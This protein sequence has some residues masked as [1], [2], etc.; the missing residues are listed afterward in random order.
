[1][2]FCGWCGIVL[3]SITE[4]PETLEIFL[5]RVGLAEVLQSL[6]SNNIES[7]KE[8]RELSVD[9]LEDLEI[10]FGDRL[11][12]K[13]VLGME[14]KL[15]AHHACKIDKLNLD[16]L[17][18]LANQNN[19]D[20]MVLLGKAF[21][22]GRGIPTDKK[23]A[24]KWFKRASRMEHPEG[25]FLYSEHCLQDANELEDMIEHAR[26]IS[27]SGE[28]GWNEARW[29][30]EE[31][32]EDKNEKYIMHGLIS[33][34][35]KALEL[36][37]Q[38]FINFYDASSNDSKYGNLE[39]L[40]FHKEIPL[41]EDVRLS[42]R[43][44]ADIKEFTRPNQIKLK[45]GALNHLIEAAEAG[46]TDAISFLKKCGIIENDKFVIPEGSIWMMNGRVVNNNM[47]TP[48]KP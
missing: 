1:M 5:K 48:K 13:R 39:N 27:K 18:N 28:L 42:L 12:L 47:G 20:A 37:R 17:E 32:L 35:A 38:Y 16:E 22:T 43:V 7:I 11:K 14:H 10:A 25:M 45:S 40:V 46:N 6:N 33:G 4:T 29:T 21:L 34:N 23:H 8:L 15:S 30:Y 36:A 41:K 19:P 24:Y 26:L 31:R 2:S 9:D 44:L 3:N